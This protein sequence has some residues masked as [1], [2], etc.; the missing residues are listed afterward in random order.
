MRPARRLEAIE[1]LDHMIK[2]IRS[3]TFGLSDQAG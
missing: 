2:Q 3:T 1:H